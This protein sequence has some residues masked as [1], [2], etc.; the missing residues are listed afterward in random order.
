MTYGHTDDG[1][2]TNSEPG[3]LITYLY[4]GLNRMLSKTYSDGATFRW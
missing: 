2:R 1:L 3:E 4:D